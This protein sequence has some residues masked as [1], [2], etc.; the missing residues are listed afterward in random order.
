MAQWQDI[1]LMIL[2]VLFSYALIPQIIQGY[3]TKK[4]VMNFQTSTITFI[5]LYFN[6]IIFISLGLYFS[7]TTLFIASSLWYVLLV[8]KIIYKN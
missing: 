6:A 8:Q 3:K 7:A 5:G 2:S 4:G 1:V